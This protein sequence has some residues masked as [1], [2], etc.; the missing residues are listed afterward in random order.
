[1][2]SDYLCLNYVLKIYWSIFHWK[3]TVHL[4]Y[5]IDGQNSIRKY[6]ANRW[7][8]PSVSICNS[9]GNTISHK[10]PMKTIRR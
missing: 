1:M 6:K 5:Y 2:T 10:S 8:Q 7:K 3:N 4:W 9:G